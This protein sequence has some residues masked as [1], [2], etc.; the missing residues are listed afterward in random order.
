MDSV[1]V[2]LLVFFLRIRKHSGEV[3]YLVTRAK[4]SD[5]RT[6]LDEE[7]MVRDLEQLHLIAPSKDKEAVE[8]PGE[9]TV[10]VHGSFLTLSRGRW[11]WAEPLAKLLAWAAATLVGAVVGTLVTL[12]ITGG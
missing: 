7:S 4:R 11:Y 12:K 2:Y 1:P 8:F 6:A 9:G 3:G 5:Y 10:I